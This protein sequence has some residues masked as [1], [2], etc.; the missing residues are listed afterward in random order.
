MPPI[1]P[2]VAFKARVLRSLM[3]HKAACGVGDDE[4]VM[5]AWQGLLQVPSIRNSQWLYDALRGEELRL[6]A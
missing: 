5:I 6:D 4:Q 1:D 2:D 3:R